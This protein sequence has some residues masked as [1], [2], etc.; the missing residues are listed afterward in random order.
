VEAVIAAR[1]SGMPLK[2]GNWCLQCG[3]YDTEPPKE[4]CK[5]PN[6]HTYD[7]KVFGLDAEEGERED[8]G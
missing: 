4:N 6:W 8:D 1:G 3:A 5:N 7:P 2:S